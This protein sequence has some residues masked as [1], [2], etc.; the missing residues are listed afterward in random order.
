MFPS[1]ATQ[2]ALFPLE[3]YISD[4][5]QKHISVWQNLSRCMAAML[6]DVVIVVGGPTRPRAMPRAMLSMK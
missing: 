1:F 4:S 3:R 5:R 6:R 2:E